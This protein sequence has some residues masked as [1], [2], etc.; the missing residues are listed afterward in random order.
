[1]R[2]FTEGDRGSTVVRVDVLKEALR[3][4]RQE[5]LSDVYLGW[6]TGFLDDE[7]KKVEALSEDERQGCTIHMG[8]PREM[9]DAFAAELTKNPGWFD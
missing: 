5:F 1:M 6:A 2:L 4:F 7:R 9:A 8:H 3:V